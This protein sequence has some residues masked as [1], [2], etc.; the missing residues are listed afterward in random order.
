MC[1]V[2]MAIFSPYSVNIDTFQGYNV[3]NLADSFRNLEILVNRDGEPNLNIGLNFIGPCGTFRE[4]P[5]AS[6]MTTGK[7]LYASSYTN[8]YSKYIKNEVSQEWEI[9]PK[10]K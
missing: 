2:A 9:N 7:E 1:N 10:T 6:E 5:R 8:L 3:T 4:L